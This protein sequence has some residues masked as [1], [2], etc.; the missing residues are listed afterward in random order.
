MKNLPLFL[1]G[2]PNILPGNL[3]HICM[4]LSSCSGGCS[5]AGNVHGECGNLN[6]EVAFVFTI[7]IP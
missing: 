3:A 2:E 1:G 5:F 6:K 7:I 4:G